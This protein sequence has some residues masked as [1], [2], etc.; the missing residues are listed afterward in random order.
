MSWRHMYLLMI[1]NISQKVV[2]KPYYY[3]Y[4][5]MSWRRICHGDTYVMETAKIVSCYSCNA[6]MHTCSII[7]NVLNPAVIHVQCV[8]SLIVSICESN[9]S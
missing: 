1:E 3:Y 2:Y 9:V 7:F 6:Y 5:Y 4:Y 8:V